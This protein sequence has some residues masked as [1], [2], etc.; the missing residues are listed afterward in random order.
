MMM[1]CAQALISACGGDEGG[2]TKTSIDP[3]D[4]SGDPTQATSAGS[5]D[6]ETGGDPTGG[7][8]AHRACDLYLDCL[9]VVTPTELPNAQQGFGHDGTCWQGDEKSAQQCL[10]ACQ[11]GLETL[12]GAHPDEPACSTCQAP[13][14]CPEGTTCRDGEC[15]ALPGQGCGNGVIDPDEVCDGNEGCDADC[16]GPA[17][18]SPWTLAGC[19]AEEVCLAI[20]AAGDVSCEPSDAGLPTLGESCDSEA[21][22]LCAEGLIC[23]PGFFGNCL[24]SGCCVAFCNFDGDKVCPGDLY[25]KYTDAGGVGTPGLGYLGYC[26]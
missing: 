23:V 17:E 12:H 3:S 6:T 26:V 18:C 25:C 14:D 22:E 16:L 15:R 19:D 8:D 7:V 13:S 5:S 4:S 24:S 1:I 2:G 20:P 11:T 9:A 10:A 21:Y